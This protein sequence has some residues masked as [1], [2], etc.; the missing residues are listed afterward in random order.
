M[1]TEYI[2]AAMSKAAYEILDETIYGE[3]QGFKGVYANEVSLK[4]SRE[5]LEFCSWRLDNI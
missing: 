1:I 2:R 3:I 5:E 4:K